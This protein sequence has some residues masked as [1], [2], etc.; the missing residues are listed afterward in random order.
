MSS[1][2][3]FMK[4][5]T[6]LVLQ[7]LYQIIQVLP[8]STA[9]LPTAMLIGSPQITPHAGF[10]VS[11]I[12]ML[13]IA[14]ELVCALGDVLSIRLVSVTPQEH[15]IYVFLFAPLHFLGII[16]VFVCA[17]PY[18]HRVISL[19]MIQLGSVFLAAILPPTAPILNVS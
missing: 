14:L 6:E 8:V 19:R 2:Y 5:V 9:A 1:K 15:S 13:I 10:N 18:V 4:I 3:L 17:C 12:L 16:L 7:V 11:L